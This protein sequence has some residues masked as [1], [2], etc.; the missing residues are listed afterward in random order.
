MLLVPLSATWLLSGYRER[1]VWG[2]AQAIIV[3]L[4]ALY[5]IASTTFLWGEMRVWAQSNAELCR[6]RPAAKKAV[7]E[8]VIEHIF[9]QRGDACAVCLGPM[10][11][12]VAPP[13]S[14]PQRVLLLV[15]LQ[16]G[17]QSGRWL[18]SAIPISLNVA[19]KSGYLAQSRS[20]VMAQ[21]GEWRLAVDVE[22]VYVLR[23]VAHEKQAADHVIDISSPSAPETQRTE[24]RLQVVTPEVLAD[25][26][27]DVILRL[28]DERDAA[29]PAA[30]QFSGARRAQARIPSELKFEW[31]S[32]A[33]RGPPVLDLSTVAA[34]QALGPPEEEPDVGPPVGLPCGHAFH[35][36]CIK[37]W[38]EQRSRC[39]LCNEITRGK[40]RLLQVIF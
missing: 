20:S 12:D 3:A 39:P 36:A 37:S 2:F 32:P 11:E 7:A 25:D 14:P 1:M 6:R 34:Q 5:L 22:K 15:R 31:D 29:T 18:R 23:L 38:L 33:A 27:A 24:L 35:E 16:N 8:Y 4:V 10:G 21:Q 26:S 9:C 30:W 40:R 19:A 13:P 17:P 28:G